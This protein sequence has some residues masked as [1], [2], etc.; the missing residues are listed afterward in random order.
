M[1]GSK[2]DSA[3]P[4]DSEVGGARKPTAVVSALGLMLILSTCISFLGYHYLQL[5]SEYRMRNFTHLK[6]INKSLDV[7]G[8]SPILRQVAIAE[9]RHNLGIAR[10]QA[11]WC[12]ENLGYLE[13]RLIRGMTG[14]AQALNICGIDVVRAAV[15]EQLLDRI[16]SANMSNATGSGSAFALALQLKDQLQLM[17]QDSEG[18]HPYV[19]MIEKRISRAIR[20]GTA[21]GSL[22]LLVLLGFLSRQLLANWQL[23]LA[24]TREIKKF[25]ARFR[26][27]IN[28]S[29]DGF[30]LVDQDGFLIASNLNFR[31]LMSPDQVDVR[32]G[33]NIATIF[34]RAVIAGHYANVDPHD[35][36]DFIRTHLDWMRSETPEKRFELSSDRHID[37]KINR[38]HAGDNVIVVNDV[39]DFH[40]NNRKLQEH[41]NLLVNANREIEFRS[42]HDPLTNLANRRYL[43]EAIAECGPGTCTMLH[44]DLDRF[45]QINDLMGHPAGDFVLRHVARILT[46]S[47][48]KG[49]LVARVGG[50]EFAILCR[51]G[52]TEDEAQNIAERILELFRQ[53]VRFQGKP[54]NLGTSIGIATSEGGDRES[55]DLLNKADAALYEAKQSG[56]G[57]ICL[58]TPELH[59]RIKKDRDLTQRF[60][61]ALEAHEFVPYYQSQ[62]C[63]TDWR[64]TGVEVL[65]RWNHP[66]HGILSPDRFL[67]IARQLGLENELDAQIFDKALADIDALDHAGFRLDCVS[68]NVSAGRIMDPGF[69]E[70]ACRKIKPPRDRFGLEI[71]ET[72]S[73][74]ELGAPLKFAIDGLRDMG[75][76]IEIDDFGSGHASIKSVLDLAPHALK[77][78]RELVQALD[79]GEQSGRMI[80]SIIEIGKAL[81]VQI[82]AEGVETEEQAVLLQAMGCHTLQ[83]FFFSRP[84]PVDVLRALLEEDHLNARDTN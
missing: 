3:L 49:D 56:K 7:V 26:A 81:D 20:Y 22:S 36:A 54:C 67:H 84:S 5:S 64:I 44:L 16:A 14:G 19:N 27:A 53:P 73:V 70:T 17:R 63:A 60:Q 40:R 43:D 2:V 50:D 21:L 25:H 52:S 55:E 38:T 39:T 79:G 41:M 29:R 80:T 34:R 35:H 83:G 8:A 62:H 32:P 10:Q 24:Q 12:T 4:Q 13:T 71:L 66:G 47:V 65:A 51:P 68:F 82:I 74:E 18:F 28:A 15:A 48:R 9:V 69:A 30:A 72:V 31:R 61:S 1:S 59:A 58:F 46:N 57:R 45:K 78:D 33:M 76:R 75:F 37:V 23:H 11:I 42:L 6:S 77:I